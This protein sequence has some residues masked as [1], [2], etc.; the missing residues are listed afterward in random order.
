MFYVGYNVLIDTS[1]YMGKKS[2]RGKSN[3]SLSRLL[4][5]VSVCTPTFNR[6]PFIK[7]AIECYKHQDYPHDRMEWIIVDD[8]TDLIEDL[9]KDVPGVKYFKFEGEKM[10]LGK[11][12][13]IMHQK[14]KGDII[15]YQDDDDYYPKDRVSHAVETLTKSKHALAAGASEIYIWFKHIQQMYQFGPYSPTHATAGTFA[16]KRELLENSAYDDTAC[17]AEERKFLKDYTVPFVQLN[18]HKTILV[19]SHEHNTFDKRKLLEGTPNPQFCKPS[20]KVVDDFVKEPHLKN[21]FMNEIEGLLENYEP[22]HPR[23]KPDVLQQIKEIDKQRAELE[24]ANVKIQMQQPDGTYKELNNKEIA[25]LL[26]KLQKEK[27]DMMEAMRNYQ[28]TVTLEK[29]DGSKEVKSL[30]EIM[31]LLQQTLH[32]NQMLK[33]S[34]GPSPTTNPT[35]NIMITDDQ[36]LQHNASTEEIVQLL[37]HQMS[38]VKRMETEM[39]MMQFQIISKNSEINYYEKRISKL[40][41]QLSNSSTDNSLDT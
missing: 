17:L 18:P 41:A 23:M 21:F 32:E 12:R 20:P 1:H 24:A 27:E 39:Q 34:G 9:V 14:S 29:E 22:G 36:G 40:E 19:F 5:F 30:N 35:T 7:T 4:P 38:E 31:Q 16:F 26:N 33:Q 15:V 37:Q 11:K 28:P 10:P 6:R 8:G 13:N 3:N 25:E 2:K